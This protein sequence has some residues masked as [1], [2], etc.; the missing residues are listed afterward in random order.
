MFSK[1]LRPGEFSGLLKMCSISFNG[2]DH[3]MKYENLVKKSLTDGFN[4][5]L[6]FEKQKETNLCENT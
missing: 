5:V 4:K 1:N 6:Y 2:G 3:S